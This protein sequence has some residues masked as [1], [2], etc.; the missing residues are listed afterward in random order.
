MSKAT[1]YELTAEV[2]QAVT[3]LNAALECRK[4]LD[5]AVNE[6]PARIAEIEAEQARLMGEIASTEADIALCDAGEVSAK[7][8]AIKRLE[9]AFK[10]GE[11]ALR[12]ARARLEAL[13]A[14]APKLDAAIDE[15]GGVLNLE[16]SMMVASLKS[17]IA[18]EIREA[19][20]ALLPIME[21]ARAIGPQLNDFCVGAYLPDPETFILAASNHTSAGANVGTN[22]LREASGLPNTI[23]EVMKPVNDALNALRA[24]RAYV[25]LAKRPVPYVRK[26]AYD[27]PGGRVDRPEEIKPPEP[28]TPRMTIEEA[29]AKPYQK[30]AQDWRGRGYAAGQDLNIAAALVASTSLD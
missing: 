15:A 26:G 7:E 11:T 28:E 8:K 21:R 29:M 19:A 2:M 13:E 12:R 18:Q 14:R 25:P 10:D 23:T 1:T 30:K 6:S 5:A 27:G 24:H 3:T 4:T 20:K 22:L 16:V 9:T 17:L